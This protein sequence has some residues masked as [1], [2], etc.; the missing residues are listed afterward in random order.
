MEGLFEIA[1][2]S[3]PKSE[4]WKSLEIKISETRPFQRGL[5]LVMTGDRQKTKSMT[6]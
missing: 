3:P 6:S 2:K 5:A 1:T 4:D